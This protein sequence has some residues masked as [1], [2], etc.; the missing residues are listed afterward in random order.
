[1][2]KKGR[3]SL[4][5]T[6]K[7]AI[8]H[9]VEKGK[10]QCQI[11]SERNLNKSTISK[12]I[13]NKSKIL[14]QY[15]KFSPTAKK[16]RSSA[17]PNVDKA[18]VEWFDCQRAKHIPISGPILIEQAKKFA[19]QL[20]E[21]NFKGTTGWLDKWKIRHSISFGTVSGEAGAVD[22]TVIE[23]WLKNIW[24][25]L[26]EGY[27]LKDIWNCDETGLFYKLLPNKT[28]TRKGQLCTGGKLSKERITVLLTANADGSEK[29]KPLVIGKYENPRCF[30][31]IKK[32]SLPVD[33]YS[34]KSAWMTQEVRKI[35]L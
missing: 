12:T 22:D 33:Y 19:T 2:E 6:D 24:P 5:L 3:I 27:E 11:A 15:A 14:A 13:K 30:K 4:T 16:A 21:V 8:I 28:M 10:Q 20:N 18:L 1:M 34:N 9:E 29:L 35:I 25:V 32:K 23:N 26:K 31:N 17:F 7:I